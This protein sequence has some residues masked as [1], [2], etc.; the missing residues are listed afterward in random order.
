MPAVRPA[1]DRLDLGPGPEKGLHRFLNPDPHKIDDAFK[2]GRQLVQIQLPPAQVLV[3][4]VVSRK[5]ALQLANLL[6]PL[7]HRVFKLG[8][9]L[10]FHP[11]LFELVLVR[12]LSDFLKVLPFTFAPLTRCFPSNE[13]GDPAFPDEHGYLWGHNFSAPPADSQNPAAGRAQPDCGY[14]KTPGF[15]VNKIKHWRRA[16]GDQIMLHNAGKKAAPVSRGGSKFFQTRRAFRLPRG[17]RSFSNLIQ[18]ES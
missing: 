8:L 14:L 16:C 9:E 17:N 11:H 18:V 5:L 6:V 3:Q 7:V 12:D 2:L 13:M 15:V 1:L 10:A 4:L